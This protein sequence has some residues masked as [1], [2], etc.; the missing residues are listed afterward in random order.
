MACRD[1]PWWTLAAED[2]PFC[3][4]TKDNVAIDA[5]GRPLP[6]TGIDIRKLVNTAVS[7]GTLVMSMWRLPSGDIAVRVEG[8]PS[9]DV[10]NELTRAAQG[11]REALENIK[12]T[13]H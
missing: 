5:Y 4:A 11:Y 10:A 12:R 1:H 9:E 13:R 2:C 6:I 7:E 3:A 8:D